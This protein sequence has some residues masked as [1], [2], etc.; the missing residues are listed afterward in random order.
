MA[1]VLY[2]YKTHRTNGFTCTL[3]I[4][5]H[6]RPIQKTEHNVLLVGHKCHWDSNPHS[7]KRNTRAGLSCCCQ[8][9]QNKSQ[10]QAFQSGVFPLQ[11]PGSGIYSLKT[12][13]KCITSP[14]FSSNSRH[15]CSHLL[16]LTLENSLFS[17]L[18]GAFEWFY[19]R[20]S[21]PL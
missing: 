18:I 14:S 12:S 4:H 16:S 21:A 1:V 2:A 7:L 8:L 17:I 6:V 5:V 11:H 13:G 20:F 19:S 15:T 10:G 9:T 3:Y